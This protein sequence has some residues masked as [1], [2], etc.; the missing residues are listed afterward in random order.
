MMEYIKN[1]TCIWCRKTKPDVKFNNRPH[2]IT[3]SMGSCTIGFDICNDCNHFFGTIDKKIK[4]F[5]SIEV[6]VNEIFNVIR[7][8]FNHN[9]NENTHIEFRSIYFNY[10]HSKKTLT[11]KD[12]FKFKRDFLTTF[13]RQFNRGL[14]EIFLQ[15]YHRQTEKGLDK[16]FDKVRQFARWNEGYLPVYSISNEKL[17][18]VENNMNKPIIHFSKM[19]LEDID[20]YGFYIFY[21]WG[22][23]FFLEV[24]SKAEI[25]RSEYLQKQANVFLLPIDGSEKIIELNN[26]LDLDFT[27]RG[28]SSSV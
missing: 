13:T 19:A 18:F 25:C 4:P 26:I 5:L 17:F 6:C 12:S 8:M 27:L 7:L 15:E 20:T 23:I 9:R 3:R 16:K 10:W 14:Y 2:S 24:T 21:L 28:L 1:G 11:I 22:Q